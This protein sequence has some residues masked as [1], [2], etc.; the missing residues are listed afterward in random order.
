MIYPRT[1]PRPQKAA[2]EEA[3]FRWPGAGFPMQGNNADNPF[4]EG[5]DADHLKNLES[6]WKSR[7][8]SPP[9]SRLLTPILVPKQRLETRGRNL[10]AH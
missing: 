7:S 8:R 10:E 9:L 3:G 4:K 5:A 1:P 6:D 2:L